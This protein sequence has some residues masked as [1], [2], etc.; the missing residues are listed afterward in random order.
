METERE[1]YETVLTSLL[2]FAY[3]CLPLILLG[4]N[5]FVFVNVPKL[6][7]FFLFFS[8]TSWFWIIWLIVIYG[9]NLVCTSETVW[10]CISDSTDFV[11]AVILIIISFTVTIV[12]DLTYGLRGLP[13]SM[14]EPTTAAD[15]RHILDRIQATGPSLAAGL[16]V[17]TRTFQVKYNKTSYWGLVDWATFPY[18]SWANIN[19]PHP[20]FHKYQDRHFN[21][22]DLE[23]VFNFPKAV[24]IKT[25]LEIVPANEET[26]EK[27]EKWKTAT[28]NRIHAGQARPGRPTRKFVEELVTDEKLAHS[29]APDTLVPSIQLPS[30][31]TAQVEARNRVV[32]SQPPWWLNYSTY[33]LCSCLLLGSFYRV[34]YWA[35]TRVVRLHFKKSFNTED[36]TTYSFTPDAVHPY[37]NY[38]ESFKLKN[39]N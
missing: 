38:V 9:T 33:M 34:L 15:F 27:Y 18:R 36:D 17:E 16:M 25:T 24:I 20:Y 28:Q 14:F 8:I 12:I 29:H 19:T 35:T 32:C 2:I 5:C 6:E 13:S 11:T 3:L 21:F 39:V 1:H 10:N 31:V 23:D 26:K 22:E 37:K 30:L 7:I 4:L